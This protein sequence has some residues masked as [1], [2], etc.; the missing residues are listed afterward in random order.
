VAADLANRLSELDKSLDE[1]GSNDSAP[2]GTGDVFNALLAE[3]GSQMPDDPVVAAIDP[4]PKSFAGSE[5]ADIT[6][7]ALRALVQ[8]LRAAVA[9]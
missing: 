8:Q 1:L 2:A 3:A 5:F 7:G 6:V 4:V 9:E